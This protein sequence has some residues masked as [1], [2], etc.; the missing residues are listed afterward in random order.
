[1]GGFSLLQ[2]LTGSLK[3]PR[4][5]CVVADLIHSKIQDFFPMLESMLYF[6]TKLTWD[7]DKLKHLTCLAHNI[8]V[9]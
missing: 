4:T 9:K 3:S 2:K 8:V 7:V 5:M 1:M 6:L